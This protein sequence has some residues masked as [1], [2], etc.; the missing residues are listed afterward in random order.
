MRKAE[1]SKP[2]TPT[3]LLVA[4][5]SVP[6][7]T[8]GARCAGEQAQIRRPH[9]RQAKNSQDPEHDPAQSILN[10]AT[11]SFTPN[12][13]PWK[14]LDQA[15]RA[16]DL[17]L[18]SGGWGL[19][20]F[21][22][23][24]IP[25]VDARRIEMSTWFRFRRAIESTPTI[26]LLLGRRAFREKLFFSGAAMPAQARKL[27]SASIRK[28]KPLAWPL[29]KVLKSKPELPI[30]VQVCSSWI[31]P[32]GQLERY[33]LTAFRKLELFS[34]LPFPS[35]ERIKELFLWRSH[36]YSFPIFPFRR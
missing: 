33:G 31:P 15:L 21:D 1:T 20:V 4:P 32:P 27:E 35:A 14:Q 34:F 17:L 7:L 11:R 3:L 24:N 28:R 16:T 8:S 29:C 2:G 9:H 19:V 10:N 18:H 6:A 5:A 13:K 36:A 26:L 12:N 25:W 30:P 23:G 22:L